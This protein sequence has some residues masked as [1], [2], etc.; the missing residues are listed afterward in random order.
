MT[1][2]VAIRGVGVVGGFGCGRDALR[3]ALREGAEPNATIETTA[4]DGPRT[5]PA[6]LADVSPLAEFVTPRKY[7]RS[8][9]IARLTT[10]ACALAL[11][12]AGLYAVDH[13]RIGLAAGTGYGGIAT[14][15]SFMES[16]L[17]YGDSGAS[18]TLFSNSGH[19]GALANA[20]ILLGITGP[21]LTVKQTELAVPSALLCARQWLLEGR[22]DLVL[23]GGF[24][25]YCPVRGYV[26][27]RF[28]GEANAGPM[29]PLELDRQ[30]AV[31]GE[32]AAFLALTR[33]E[34]DDAT[35][36]FIEE[37]TVRGS[38][39]AAVTLP[40]NAIVLIDA[41]GHRGCGREY[42]RV[43]ARDTRVAAFAPLFGSMPS[44]TAFNLAVAATALREGVLP[45]PPEGGENA[46]LPSAIRRETPLT[47]EPLCCLSLY[48]SGTR[49][50]IT[51]S[52]KARDGARCE[53]L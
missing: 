12:D 50:L 27:D 53:G 40:S 31:L 14:T 26:R 24:D 47:G 10:L 32:G 18:P 6:H 34:G 11:K 42:G 30:S 7:R 46:E 17:E 38:G 28:F 3:Q 45:A 2:R 9:K 43:L 51:L 49:S 25:E 33:D 16:A 19:S 41:D 13:S 4:P 44:G 5:Y 36:A 22:A 29:R 39:S 52:R 21:S 20:S 8:D 37:V 48:K 35:D 15:F 1:E 23:F